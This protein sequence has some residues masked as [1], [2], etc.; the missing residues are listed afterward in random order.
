[1]QIFRRRATEEEMAAGKDEMMREQRRLAKEA[2][3][4]RMKEREEEDAQEQDPVKDSAPMPLPAPD[5]LPMVQSIATPSQ[6][7]PQEEMRPGETRALTMSE[8]KKIQRQEVQEGPAMTG[9]MVGTGDGVPSPL[10]NEEQLRRIEELQ[11]AAPLLM[12]R[13]TEPEVGRPAWL[14]EEERKRLE[15][16]MQKEKNRDRQ[17][18]YQRL[19]DSEKLEMLERIQTL[20][21]DVRRMS[22]ECEASR[23][24]SEDLKKR[25]ESLNEVNKMM[26]DEVKRLK[27]QERRGREEFGTPADYEEEI[28]KEKR[29]WEEDPMNT[30]R[31]GVDSEERRKEG[32]AH[33]L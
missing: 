31:K 13:H 26:T 32:V 8:E 20:E 15:A 25:N 7:S 29:S 1:M 24:E 22:R 30:P 17:R 11:R 4:E 16:E 3:E 2:V 10:F 14:V 27:E 5:Q 6:G 9:G 33:R 18:V 23:R 12:G 21:E 28:E 19:N